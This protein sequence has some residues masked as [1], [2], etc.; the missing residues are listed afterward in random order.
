MIRAILAIAAVALVVG[1]GI[2]AAVYYFTRDDA[3][4]P[5]LTLHDTFPTGFDRRA[6]QFRAVAFD[7]QSRCTGIFDG[8]SNLV[9][10]KSEP[11]THDGIAYTNANPSAKDILNANQ[12]PNPDYGY[13]GQARTPWPHNETELPEIRTDLV[14]QF[15]YVATSYATISDVANLKP[16]PIPDE[17]GMPF[18]NARTP[19]V[20]GGN[21][22][23][24]GGT[25][26]LLRGTSTQSDVALAYYAYRLDDL[27]PEALLYENAALPVVQANGTFAVVFDIPFQTQDQATLVLIPFTAHGEQIRAVPA[28]AVNL[29]SLHR[30]ETNEAQLV[31]GHTGPVEA[32]APPRVQ[33]L[34]GGV[35]YRGKTL[36]A[37]AEKAQSDL[38]DRLEAA[39]HTAIL[40]QKA[41]EPEAP[42]HK[43]RQ[44]QKAAPIQLTTSTTLELTEGA[45]ANTIHTSYAVKVNTK[46]ATFVVKQA[47]TSATVHGAAGATAALTQIGA[48]GVV[49]AKVAAEGPTA[50]GA[51]EAA[52]RI[53][54]ARGQVA[55]LQPRPAVARDLL[56]GPQPYFLA[57]GAFAA[58]WEISE[59][60]Q[61]QDGV[62]RFVHHVKA[63][64][65]VAETLF[66][67]SPQGAVIVAATNL[68]AFAVN[69]L[70]PDSLKT[71]FSRGVNAVVFGKVPKESAR[72]AFDEAAPA[73]EAFAAANGA[74]ILEHKVAKTHDVPGAG[75]PLAGIALVALAVAMRRWPPSVGASNDRIRRRTGL[76]RRQAHSPKHELGPPRP[77]RRRRTLD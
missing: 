19:V 3:G 35:V 64:R 76:V 58:G 41:F 32:P 22:D 62:D 57:A 20:L 53:L 54:D 65:I 42:L 50:K 16:V 12:L 51:V 27:Q 44:Y 4:A 43:A 26:F 40:V 25:R 5:D 28:A 39:S 23:G 63:A 30:L 66:S 9:Q 34:A 46:S 77:T 38:D 29:T 37:V 6:V 7:G 59:A 61:A 21:G 74:G 15:R 18:L 69:E 13:V 11:W 70:L 55:E 75:L 36:Q 68:A 67:I 45:A 47:T 33:T 10:G 8:L 60:L 31:V 2:F 1:S 49:I 56:R 14:C 48:D 72:R 52:H 71:W 24:A 73:I 17:I